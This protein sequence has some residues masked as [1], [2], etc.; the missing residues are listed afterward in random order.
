MNCSTLESFVLRA[1]LLAACFLTTTRGQMFT[2]LGDFPV[3]NINYIASVRITGLA[4]NGSVVGTGYVG[5][6][7]SAF[8]W[9]QGAG[10]E[11]L[12][13]LPGG[14]SSWANGVSDDGA[15]IIG[16]ST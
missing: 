7:H 9:S 16:A 2:S 10:F 4:N 13:S 5:F 12:G 11:L 3:S 15:V 14:S 6:F 8:R 1:T